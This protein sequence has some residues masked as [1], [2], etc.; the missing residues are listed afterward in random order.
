[1]KYIPDTPREFSQIG[2]ALSRLGTM[3]SGVLLVTDHRWWTFATVGLSWLGHEI[4]EYFKLEEGEST[5]S[6]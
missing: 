4:S 6:E 1:M 3:I 2:S 5:K